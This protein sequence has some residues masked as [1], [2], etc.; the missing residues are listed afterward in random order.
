[1]CFQLRDYFSNVIG[2][3]VSDAKPLFIQFKVYGGRRHYVDTK[4]IHEI[5]RTIEMNDQYGLFSMVVIPNR[6][7]YSHLL[8]FGGDLEAIRPDDVRRE[9]KEKVEVLAN[10]Y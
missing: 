1:M 5:Q 10:R 2:V 7:L 9:M 4:R 6:E 3:S 8:G